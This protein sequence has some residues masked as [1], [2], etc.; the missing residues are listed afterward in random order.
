MANQYVI[1]IS[2]NQNELSII[3]AKG[4]KIILLKTNLSFDEVMSVD[5]PI[6]MNINDEEL[7]LKR[8]LELNE[9]YNI[10]AVFSLNEYRVVLSSKV[11]AALNLNHHLEPSAALLCESK[12]KL[13]QHLNDRNISYVHYESICIK[14]DS[15]V[16]SIKHINFPLVIKP[17]NDSGSKNIFFC[18]DEKSAS[19]AIY[20]LKEVKYNHVGQEIEKEILVEEFLEGPEFSVESY[21]IDSETRIVGI[22]KKEISNYPYAFEV[23]HQFPA[24]L[25][26]DDSTSIE[27]LVSITLEAI[28]FNNGIAHTEVKLT[29][30]GPK[31]IEVNA[32][33]GG[34]RIMDL[35]HHVHH[36]D[37]KQLAFEINLGTSSLPCLHKQKEGKKS[38]SIHFFYAEDD[39]IASFQKVIT[40]QQ[41]LESKWYIQNKSPVKKT[42]TNF[43]RLGYVIVEGNLDDTLTIKQAYNLHIETPSLV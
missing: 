5:V 11:A 15:C 34:D 42:T 18:T 16:S 35:V 32:R 39:G 13:R 12:N 36:I 3:K 31:I 29:E 17:S 8:C 14:G 6:E 25:G 9:K 21:T 7:V 20:K 10:A 38:A 24:T 23:G 1:T 41:I 22:T 28:G 30:K 27:D 40:N 43:N 4:Y 2:P 26:K 19:E 33:P 37:L